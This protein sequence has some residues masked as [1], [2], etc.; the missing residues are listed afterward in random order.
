MFHI[1]QVEPCCWN[2]YC[3]HR[4]TKE[5]LSILDKLDVDDENH[6]AERLA[7]RY[8]FYNDEEIER[9]KLT[10][11]QYLKP[12]LW[13]LFEEPYSSIAAKLVAGISILFICLS[14]LSF[15]LKTLDS[16]E[17]NCERK[18]NGTVSNGDENDMVNR[19]S[20]VL[21][22]IQYI[23]NAWFTFELVVRFL[24]SEFSYFMILFLLTFWYCNPR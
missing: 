5:T 7:C 6:R 17:T 12:Q 16:L 10:Y 1:K 2:A 4:D 20:Q 24:V 11:W 23:C 21:C 22:Y 18:A 19:Y 14:V 3:L 8:N 15:C 9:A 13:A